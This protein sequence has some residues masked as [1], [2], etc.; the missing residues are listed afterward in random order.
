MSPLALAPLPQH[1]PGHE[2]L[3]RFILIE[4]Y[5]GHEPVH[6]GFFRGRGLIACGPEPV[7][8]AH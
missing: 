8:C 4:F 7:A 2:P 1:P 5:C 6:C 3:C